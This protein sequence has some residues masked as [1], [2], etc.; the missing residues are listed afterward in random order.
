M[1]D[2]TGLLVPALSVTHCVTLDKPM[3]LSGPRFSA[4]ANDDY[5]G[6]GG[7]GQLLLRAYFLQALF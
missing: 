2:S 5:C 4:S 3:P 7:G 6:D 1:G